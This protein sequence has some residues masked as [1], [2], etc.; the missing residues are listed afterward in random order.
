MQSTLDWLLASLLVVFLRN[1]SVFWGINRYVVTHRCFFFQLLLLY[2]KTEGSKFSS[3]LKKFE[4]G[5]LRDK[6]DCNCLWPLITSRSIYACQNKGWHL[7]V[8]IQFFQLFHSDSPNSLRTVSILKV[9]A[10]GFTDGIA[11]TGILLDRLLT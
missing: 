1:S 3:L 9:Y 11:S 4:F 8:P 2:S 5:S 10:I 7:Y 6:C